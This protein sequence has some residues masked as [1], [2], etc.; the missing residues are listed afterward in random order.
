MN[1]SW[2]CCSFFTLLL[3][4]KVEPSE[5]EVVLPLFGTG[6]ARFASF[7]TP[8]SPLSMRLVVIALP[9]KTAV[10]YAMLTNETQTLYN[11]LS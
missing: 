11:R 7:P 1:L 3:V 4:R 6:S 10:T 2:G 9:H 5:S 8:D